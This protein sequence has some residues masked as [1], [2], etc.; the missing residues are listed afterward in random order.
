MLDPTRVPGEQWQAANA[1]CSWA[2]GRLGIEAD[3]IGGPGEALMT[4]TTLAT[5]EA[6]SPQRAALC[7]REYRRTAVFLQAMDAAIRAARERFPGETIHVVEAGCGPLAPLTLPFALR[8]APDEV[9]FTLLDLHQVSLAGAR[10]LAEELGVSASVRTLPAGDAGEVRF[11]EADR[12]HVIG[13]EVL[14]RALKK[15]PQVAVTRALAPQLREGGFFLPERIDIDVGFVH[16]RRQL[17][18]LAG[19]QCSA[20]EDE[21]VERLGRVFSFEALGPRPETQGGMLEAGAVE[22][23][24]QGGER[25]PLWLLTRLAVFRAHVLGDFD[26][27]LTMPERLRCPADLAVSGGLLE[28]SYE[29][30]ASPGLRLKTAKVAA[31]AD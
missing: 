24:S 25:G 5:G 13:C 16:G 6:I 7:V 29:M 1:W 14:R 12:P 30:S 28:F 19:E 21:P 11:A 2:M 17:R 23:P 10:R 26:C 9:R 4:P 20:G 22:V 15:E 18:R 31:L 3:S 8:Y 27:S